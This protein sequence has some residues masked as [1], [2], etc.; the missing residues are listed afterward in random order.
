M[1]GKTPRAAM[2]LV[3]RWTQI[4]TDNGNCLSRGD[5]EARRLGLLIPRCFVAVAFL[6]ALAPFFAPSREAVA[7][8]LKKGA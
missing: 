8:E 5:A 3:H 6:R 2:A 7:V 1:A 4:Y